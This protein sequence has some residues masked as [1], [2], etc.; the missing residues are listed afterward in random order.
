MFVPFFE[1]EVHETI[2]YEKSKEI[3]R[4]LMKAQVEAAK[5]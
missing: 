4:A 5:K 1:H 3:L 2:P